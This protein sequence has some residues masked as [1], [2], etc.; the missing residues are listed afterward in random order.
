M[1]RVLVCPARGWDTRKHT[2]VKIEEFAH[3]L[4]SRECVECVRYTWFIAMWKG[5]V[6]CQGGYLACKRW[7]E[8]PVPWRWHGYSQTLRFRFSKY[9]SVCEGI[10]LPFQ[11][12]GFIL[13]VILYTN[14]IGYVRFV[15]KWL[16]FLLYPTQFNG[17]SQQDCQEVL[18]FLLDGLHED[19]NR[20][21]KKPYLALPVSFNR[22]PLVGCR[23]FSVTLAEIVCRV[24]WN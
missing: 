8:E 24:G 10:V 20:V 22:L 17:F 21:F 13:Y 1:C 16:S 7:E 14:Q 19:L 2:P 18:S 15:L 23:L 4:L 9:L 11:D 6:C 3:E 5:V 12:V